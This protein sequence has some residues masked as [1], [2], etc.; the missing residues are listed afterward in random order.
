ML[1]VNEIKKKVENIFPKL[2]EGVIHRIWANKPYDEVQNM[3]FGFWF[4]E[5]CPDKTFIKGV[6]VVF[7][8]ERFVLKQI[9][10]LINETY[11]IYWG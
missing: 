6:P 3:G 8:S 2:H 10:D 11:K 5:K 7:N 9:D 1:T 4:T